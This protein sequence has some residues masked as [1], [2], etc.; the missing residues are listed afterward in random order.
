MTFALRAS[1]TPKNSVINYRHKLIAVVRSICNLPLCATS[2]FV[3]TA[4]KSGDLA[5]QDPLSEVDIQTIVHVL[6]MLSSK[7]S[8][9]ANIAKAELLQSVHYA[10]C[11]DPSPALINAF[12]SGS[13]NGNFH[14]TRI[15]YHHQS[16][17]TRGRKACRNLGISFAVPTNEAP[18]ISF[19]DSG[20]IKAKLCCNFL[21]HLVQ[22]LAGEKL[23][24]LPDQGEV[25]RA[26]I[27]D[28]F[29]K[30]S[31]WL[32]NGLNMHFRD[33]RFIHQRLEIYSSMLYPLTKIKPVGE[34]F[35]LAAESVVQKLRPS[36]T[37]FA[38]A[39]N[40]W[41]T[42]RKDMIKL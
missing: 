33:W 31:S 4:R 38:I 2:H 9:V 25:A 5:F 29:Y 15:R 19:H 18:S 21:H 27:S 40:I 14:H 3:F 41:L 11:D 20:P 42:Y 28:S 39:N 34:I 10:A 17:W 32:F 35:R 23:I 13:T 30:G 22:N 6:K 7:D 12:L 8:F 1:N 16:L 36:L 26:F 24:D 37:F